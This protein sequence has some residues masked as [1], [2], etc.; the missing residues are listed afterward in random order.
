VGFFV[1]E[2]IIIAGLY[3]IYGNP[4]VPSDISSSPTLVVLDVFALV[5]GVAVGFFLNERT[6]VRNLATKNGRVV[7]SMIV[8][9]GRFQAVS[10]MG[11]AVVIVVQLGLL[12]A[13]A[14][15]PA[16]GNIIGGIVA[17]PVTYFVSMRMVWRV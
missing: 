7:E 9:L 10:A 4:D 11:N 6:T 16:I 3:F 17:F 13:F 8:R 15:S 1:A 2:A 5:T 12:A 14:I